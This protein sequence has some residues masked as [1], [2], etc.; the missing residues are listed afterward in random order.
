MKNASTPILVSSGQNTYEK[1]TNTS[2]ATKSAHAALKRRPTS[3][4]IGFHRCAA[5]QKRHHRHRC[6]LQ[7]VHLHDLSGWTT[8]AYSRKNLFV[9]PERFLGQP[10]P[11]T[12]KRPQLCEE[13][14]HRRW[15]C[16]ESVDLRAPNQIPELS[17]RRQ[18]V[19][20]Q[21]DLMYY[22]NAY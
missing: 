18:R 8:E 15:E 2:L 4:L 22:A 14:R 10:P 20:I 21:A 1:K 17:W 19:P 5:P 11:R 3:A 16:A 9:R 13:P 12:T 6:A 7:R